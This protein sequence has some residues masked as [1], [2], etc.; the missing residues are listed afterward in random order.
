MLMLAA[1]LLLL[2]AATAATAAEAEAASAWA[3]RAD[4][5]TPSDKARRGHILFLSRESEFFF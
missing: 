1:L 4:L 2:A 3:L 5:T